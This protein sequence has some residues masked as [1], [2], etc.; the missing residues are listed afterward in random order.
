MISLNILWDL[1]K[2]AKGTGFLLNSSTKKQNPKKNRDNFRAKTDPTP[3]T[4]IFVKTS[5]APQKVDAV[6]PGQ[7]NGTF[8]APPK[9]NAGGSPYPVYFPLNPGCLLGIL[10]MVYE[11][12]P[13]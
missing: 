3:S 2:H 7:P 4:P 13:T 12:I 1:E 9:Q 8:W 6:G 11:I 5:R 10:T